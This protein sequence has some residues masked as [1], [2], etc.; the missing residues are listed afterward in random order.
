MT[1]CHHNHF[2]YDDDNDRDDDKDKKPLI[3]ILMR[4]AARAAV[5]CLPC[6]A[7]T[8]PEFDMVAI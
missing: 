4:G 8:M 2:I 3:S 6:D 5:I 1:L 7:F